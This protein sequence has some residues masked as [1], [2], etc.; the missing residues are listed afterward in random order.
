MKV[1]IREAIIELEAEAQKDGLT[2]VPSGFNRLGSGYFRLGKNRFGLLLQLRPAMGKN[3]AIC[4]FLYS[5]WA[6]GKIIISPLRFFS[7]EM[8]SISIGQRLISAEA[9][10]DS[11]KKK[12]GQLPSMNGPQFGS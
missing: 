1:I 4:S 10:L 6:S 5:K 7:L 2:G 12:R 8:S 9:E 11:D 3:G